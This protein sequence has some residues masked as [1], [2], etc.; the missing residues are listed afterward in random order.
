[1]SEQTMPA[2][3]RT[4]IDLWCGADPVVRYVVTDPALRPTQGPRPYLHPIRT[5]A[6][7]VVTDAAPEDHPWHLGVSVALQ[8]VAKT[9]F[10]GGRTFLRDGGPTWR[11]DHGRIERHRLLQIGSDPGR[12]DT[13][14]EELHWRSPAGALQIVEHRRIAVRPSPIRP[15]AWVL[16]LAFTLTNAAQAEL[17]L[18]SPAT[19]GKV[20][21][22]YGGFFWRL[23]ASTV[24]PTVFTAE[25]AGET[26]VHE[27]T[28]DWLAVH[29][30]GPDYTLVFAAGD[31]R[32]AADPWFVRIADYPGIG[33]SLAV[34]EPIRLAAARA[35]ERRL[36]IVVADGHLDAEE[37]ARAAVAAA[38]SR[39]A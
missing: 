15:G 14:S 4:E 20:G 2:E 16:D 18:G 13:L 29:G 12:P 31:A 26:A 17:E 8:D 39:P 5:A 33:S 24:A 9:N 22:G 32:T 34:A 23:P 11:D 19:N 10:W 28:A 25:S 38:S 1:M 3:A 27:S 21:G 35:L 7:A 30:H 36:L 37:A 6:G